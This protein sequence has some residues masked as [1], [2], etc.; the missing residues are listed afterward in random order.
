MPNE[1][2]RHH[3]LPALGFSAAFLGAVHMGTFVWLT[4]FMYK[5]SIRGYVPAGITGMRNLAAGAVVVAIY[6]IVIGHR[7]KSGSYLL[8]GCLGVPVALLGT[9]AATGLLLDILGYSLRTDILVSSLCAGLCLLL[10]LGFHWR[11]LRR[12][13]D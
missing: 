1:R 4:A 5:A 11:W 3:L 13:T 7:R 10:A 9:S 12:K 8:G 6:M 2:S